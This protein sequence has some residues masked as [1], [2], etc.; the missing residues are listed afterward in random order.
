MSDITKFNLDNENEIHDYF[1]ENGYVVIK[2]V[3]HHEKIDTFLAAYNSVKTHPLFVYYS[4]SLH[5]NLR[6]SL[7][8]FGYIQE[9]MENASRLVFFKSFSKSFKNC[10]YD[11]NIS[12]ALSLITGEG[13]HVSWQNMFFDKST[14]TIEHQDSWYLD[15]DPE[16]DLIG[17]WYALEDIHENAGPFFVVPKSH[18]KVG[19][20]D[21]KKYPNHNVFVNAIRDE[22][23]DDKSLHKIPM[24]LSKGDILLWHPFLI[25][26]SFSCNDES[27]S[28]KS[29][30]SHFY[31]SNKKPRCSKGNVFSIY[32]HELPQKTFNNHITAAYRHHDSAYN[33]RV[34]LLY[35]KNRILGE[36]K[37]ISMHREDYT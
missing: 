7:N 1:N 21:R 6:P 24:C 19:P 36:Y 22:M 25:H 17:V 11:E 37:K 26:G 15:T 3:I 9:A 13:H 35:L 4:Q 32:N 23:N 2:N 20:L 16:G 8:S 27:Y 29:F 34:Y 33:I 5:I 10:I 31:P 12:T 14:G 28:R 18:T 30:T